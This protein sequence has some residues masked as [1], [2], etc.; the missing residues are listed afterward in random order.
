MDPVVYSKQSAINFKAVLIGRH[1]KDSIELINDE[2]VPFKYC[3]QDTSMDFSADGTS[4]FKLTPSS[5]VISP[6]SSCL[7]DVIFAPK[8]E[9]Q[10]NFNLL[11]KINK[12][13]LPIKI[14]IK[15]EGYAIREKLY[16]DHSDGSMYHL[17][18][19]NDAVGN[20]LDFGRVQVNEKSIKRVTIVNLGKF[21]IDFSWKGISK[22]PLKVF[23]LVGT[24][25]S[26]GS[27]V[28]EIQFMSKSVISLKSTK[29]VCQ[30]ANGGTY[31]LDLRG[32][33]T[34]P[35]LKYSLSSIDFGTQ[36]ISGTLTTAPAQ[37]LLV[38]TNVDL[39]DINVEIA[40]VDC[41]WLE[42]KKGLSTIAPGES[43]KI[44]VKFLPE[45]AIAYSYSLCIEINGIASVQMPIKGEGSEI[46]I[47]SDQ[48]ILNFGA[49]RVGSLASK[50]LKLTNSSKIPVSFSI[51]GPSIEKLTKLGYTISHMNE[52]TLRPK[53]SVSFEVKFAPKKRIVQ[54]S[55]E[56]F[57][58]VYGT[59][60]PVF[61]VSGA[62]QGVQAQFDTNNISFGVVV[63]RSYST[64]KFQLINSG[65]IGVKFS[66]DPKKFLPDFSIRPLVGY[67]PPGM[68]VSL[69][70]TFNPADLKQDK[71]LANI[72][73][74]IEGSAPIY[75]SLSG[76]CIP[77]PANGELIKFNTPVRSTEIKGVAVSNK[78]NILWRIQPIFENDYWT[79]AKSFEIEP[80]QSKTYDICFCPLVMD[81]AADGGRHEGSVFMPLPDGV[82]LL[83][84]LV[85]TTEGPQPT[86]TITREIMCKIL[87]TETLVVPNWM[88][89]TQRF[90]VIVEMARND[91]G[92]TA[93]GSEFLTI[94]PL[95]TKEYK[96]QFVAYKE[97]VTNAKIIFRN[98]TTLEFLYFNL[99]YKVLPGGV[100]STIEMNTSVRQIQTQEITIM[101][102]L[103]TSVTFNS[104]V[105][106]SEISVPY[107][108]SI[109]AKYYYFK[110]RSEVVCT[111]EFVPL[112]PRECL[113][114]LTLTST[115]LGVY[116]YDLKLSA[117]AAG[118]GNPLIFKIGFG[119]YHTQ[120]YRFMSYAKTKTDYTCKIENADFTV[121][122]LVSA[123]AGI[124]SP[125]V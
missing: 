24:I 40:T 16:F 13:P 46:M 64:R 114:K 77:Q 32:I 107:T 105:N 48:K 4:V 38:I 62:C 118:P 57:V 85:G 55:E 66:W 86:D 42:I 30:I 50:S 36:Y 27:C 9:K 56:I 8:C 115:D 73:C 45:A 52:I 97:S 68:E 70:V 87:H 53:A 112:Q 113:S 103:L 81:G 78:S 109:A 117:V 51:F 43:T 76:S 25:V 54:V 19:G 95:S 61:I 20:I 49:L 125:N 6:N 3:F 7:I 31:L 88:T 2:P 58:Q 59:I 75:L 44:M 41:S 106:N 10:F 21:N 89:K 28:C 26:G 91:I 37:K 83:Y 35:N 90:R 92:T 34:K 111:I 72:P 17:V 11:C 121:E 108:F 69:E 12:K 99:L 110:C 80:G 104:S 124:Y 119:G 67:V 60:I 18:Q 23:P 120:I 74:N 79:G 1:I 82:G 71:F 96:L 47:E 65:D 22:S 33:S 39:V 123:P 94:G 93:K 29:F 14:N 15:A 98:E 5:G 63:Y 116:Q 101:N 100:I 84:K 102:P 122:K